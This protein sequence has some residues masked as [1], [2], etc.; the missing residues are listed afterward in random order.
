MNQRQLRHQFYADQFEVKFG[1]GSLVFQGTVM[2]CGITSVTGLGSI[3]TGTK[4]ELLQ[5]LKSNGGFQSI[6][7]II[8]VLGEFQF[9]EVEPIALNLGFEVISEHYNPMH[10]RKQKLYKLIL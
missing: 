2:G 8:A 6:G 10:E 7:I 1:G 9:A 3:K 4:E 5:T